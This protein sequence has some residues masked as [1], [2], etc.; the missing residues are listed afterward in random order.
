M[1][2]Y[3]KLGKP[4]GGLMTRWIWVVVLVAAVGCGGTDADLQQAAP[5]NSADADHETLGTWPNVVVS[6]NNQKTAADLLFEIMMQVENALEPP[7]Q[8]TAAQLEALAPKIAKC[9]REKGNLSHVDHAKKLVS[10]LAAATARDWGTC[11]TDLD[12]GH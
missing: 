8:I 4:G 1:R 10:A 6:V 9:G 11:T 2:G 5:A 7:R 3:G 12:A